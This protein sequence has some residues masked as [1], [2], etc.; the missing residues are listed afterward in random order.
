MKILIITALS[1]LFVSCSSPKISS[2]P[3]NCDS[4]KVPSSYNEWKGS[5]E[6][7]VKTPAAPN[8]AV[9]DRI[10]GCALLSFEFDKNGKARNVKI[11][12]EFPKKYDIGNMFAL[13]LLSNNFPKS[14]NTNKQAAVFHFNIERKR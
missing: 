13:Y 8:K 7:E 2:S 1:F 14:A 4:L 3:K 11:L 6:G 12:E 10:Q 5:P 9:L